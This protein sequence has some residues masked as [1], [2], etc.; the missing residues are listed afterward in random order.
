[1]CGEWKRMWESVWGEWGS[2]LAF[3]IRRKEWG[4]CREVCQSVGS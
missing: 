4:R 1:M 3:G 2:V